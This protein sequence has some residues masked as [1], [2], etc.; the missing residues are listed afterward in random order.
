MKLKKPRF[1]EYTKPNVFALILYPLAV[2]LELLNSI[3]TRPVKNNFKIKTVCFGNIYVGGTGKTSLCIKLN[4]LLNK[5]KIKSCFI[6]KIYKNQQ[7][8]QKLLKNNGR[9]FLSLKR[10]EAIKNAEKEN[11]EI[12]IM[13]DGLQDKSINPDVNFVCFNNVNWV[14]NGMTIPAGPLRENIKQLKKYENVFL[15][16]NLEELETIKNKILLINPVAKIHIGK[17][18][19]INMSDFKKDKN[20][21]IFSGIGNHKTFINMLKNYGLKILKDLEFPDHYSY[22][23]NDIDEIVKEANKLSCEIITTEKDY[24][25][26]ENLNPKKIKYIKSE[27][28]ILDEEKFLKT[29]L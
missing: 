26:L 17:Y 27:I 5:R 18:K 8:E 14:G 29:I 22:N 25:R 15:N 23:Q 28:K 12:A 1:W 20:Y 19:P 16:G 24:V 2:L 10:I 4:N 3:K 9:L 6:K 13:D 7:D 11:Y 21:L